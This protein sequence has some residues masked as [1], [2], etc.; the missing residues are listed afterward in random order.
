[1]R[2]EIEDTFRIVNKNIKK[3]EEY[4]NEN[5]S[6]KDNKNLFRIFLVVINYLQFA[7]YC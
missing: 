5:I 7:I 4:K 1:M 2:T 3:I 6:C